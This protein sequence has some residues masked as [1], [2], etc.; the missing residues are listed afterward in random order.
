MTIVTFILGLSEIGRRR[1]LW[2]AMKVRSRETIG[3]ESGPTALPCVTI[4]CKK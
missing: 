2:Y 1:I 4:D 3:Q